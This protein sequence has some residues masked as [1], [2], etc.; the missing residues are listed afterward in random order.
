MFKWAN[1]PKQVSGNV[2]MILSYV[3][4]DLIVRW[5]EKRLLNKRFTDRG[6]FHRRSLIGSR[7]W[8]LAR[9][10]GQSALSLTPETVA[11]AYR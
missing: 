9:S 7:S 10:T 11:V 1:Q 4:R 2:K 8:Q 5:K 3:E 6:A